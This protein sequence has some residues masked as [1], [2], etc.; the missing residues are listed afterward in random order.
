MHS[1]PP[2]IFITSWVS[3][4]WRLLT[5]YLKPDVRVGVESVAF[6]VLVAY[7]ATVQRFGRHAKDERID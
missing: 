4:G 1:G 3:M 2:V 7:R 5:L 6:D